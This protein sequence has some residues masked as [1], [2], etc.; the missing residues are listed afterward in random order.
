MAISWFTSTNG[1][2]TEGQNVTIQIWREGDLSQSATFLASHVQN[3]NIN[4][5]S[6]AIDNDTEMWID[7]PVF[8]AP[9]VARQS[10]SYQ[11]YSDGVT[12]GTELSSVLFN[13]VDNYPN[14]TYRQGASLLQ[15]TAINDPSAAPA[16]APAP[17][18]TPTVTQ[19]TPLATQTVSAPV[20]VPNVVNN[21]VTNVDN[22]VTNN[23][24]DNSVTNNFVNSFNTDNSTNITGSF[25]TDNSVTNYSLTAITSNND[26]SIGKTINGSGTLRGTADNDLLTGGLKG[27]RL[28]GSFGN[29]ELIGGGGKDRLY[30]GAGS[31]VFN[32][33]T[34]NSRSDADR[35]YIEREANALDA[36][37]I[38]SIG[39][40]DRI[41]I[42]G[43]TGDLSVRGIDGGLG[44]FDNDVLQAIYTGNNFN[45]ST[46]SNQL[47]AV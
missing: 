14:W 6:Q 7:R 26:Y 5:A 40:S 13:Q 19:S 41:Y 18:P 33:G 24:T 4:L 9:G 43:S 20:S 44:I 45:A 16:P 29:D 8:F 42:Q 38:E 47:V 10:V 46:L 12:E 39:K 31:N 1:P 32:A 25:N 3:G 11:T 2:V 21:V 34:S 23:Y 15:V 27:D 35:L 30:G 36:D 37:I 17:Q 22:S 28:L